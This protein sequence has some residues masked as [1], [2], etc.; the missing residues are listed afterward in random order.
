MILHSFQII[1]NFLY[2]CQS[3]SW[4]TFLLKLD[5]Y[6]DISSS[7]GYI[8]LKFFGDIPEML[9]HN[10]QIIMNFLCAC[11]SVSWLTSLLKSDNYKDISSSGWDIVLIFLET[12]LGYFWTVSKSFVISL[13]SVSL[14]IG[15]FTHW[16]KANI[17][18]L[19]ALDEISFWFFWTH[20]WDVVTLLQNKS[21]YLFV[22]QS[23]SW[24]TSLLKL[25][26]Y[27][28]I[29][30]LMRYLSDFFGNILGMLVH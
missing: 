30:F 4:L 2:V 1:P 24:L 18:I 22:C 11:Q 8:F 25:D 12:F 23:V 10:F 15:L 16:N 20:S 3:V 14:I 27:K 17:G 29:H 13:M 6:W 7:G 28:D 19:S 5:K 26:K 21:E 9:L